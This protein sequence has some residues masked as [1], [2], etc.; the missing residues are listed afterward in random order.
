MKQKILITTI[1]LSFFTPLVYA[2]KE[3]TY[4]Q[5]LETLQKKVTSH[6]FYIDLNGKGG[7]D[8]LSA[9]FIE[10]EKMIYD[11][12]SFISID[13]DNHNT[14]DFKATYD[15]SKMDHKISTKLDDLGYIIPTGKYIFAATGELTIHDEKNRESYVF[16]KVAIG[17]AET[18][19][20]GNYHINWILS[21]DDG[22]SSAEQSSSSVNECKAIDGT[23]FRISGTNGGITHKPH[24]NFKQL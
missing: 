9:D 2:N 10:E 17:K 23:K 6:K 7:K 20:R 1:A 8:V 24:F 11:G 16:P 3:P 18:P 19:Y 15:V 5:Q 4:E 21:C 22:Y 14:F 13:K 12:G